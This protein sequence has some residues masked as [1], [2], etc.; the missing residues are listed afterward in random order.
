MEPS[1]RIIP[2]SQIKTAS[3]SDTAGSL[4]LHDT[5]GGEFEDRIAKW[6][7]TQDNAR[8]HMLANL[9]GPSAPMRLL[10]ERQIVSAS[11]HMP[12]MPQSNIHLD[13]LMGRDETLDSTDFFL[14]MESGP[15]LSIHNDMEKKLRL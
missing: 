13:I 7:E 2:P 6:E 1:Y 12:G 3:I 10:M 11:P 4:G 14:G 9:Y 5:L 8:L 15:A